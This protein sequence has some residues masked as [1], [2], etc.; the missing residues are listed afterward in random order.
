VTSFFGYGQY[1]YVKVDDTYT[2]DQLI[3][4][5]LVNSACDLVSNVRYQ[6]GSG[7]PAAQNIMAAGYF[8]RNG[9]VFPFE[10]GIVLSTDKSSLVPGPKGPITPSAN[11]FRWTGDVDLNNLINDAGGWPGGNDARSTIIDFEFISVQSTV[12]FEY[13]FASNSYY[14]CTWNCD[15]G[16]LFGAWLIDTTT[17]TGQNLAVIPG[18]TDPISINTLRD[19]AKTGVT[20]G[21]VS[22]NAHLFDNAYGAGATM[23]P[24][25]SAPVNY[26]GI[27]VAMQSLTANVVVGRKYRIKLAIIDFCTTPTHTSA[28]FF[29]E[30]S[31]DIGNLD[32]GAPVLIADDNGLCVGDNYTL[33]SGLDPTLFTF[34]WYKDGIKIPGE[35]SPDL[36]VNQT[37]DYAVKAYIPTVT[38]C[39]MEAEP[40][41]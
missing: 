39:V 23:Q 2:P 13:V 40:V 19:G 27:T 30:G 12:G 29:N 4:E 1:N 33:K 25:I 35:T 31:F 28:V 18:T 8:E 5:V 17:N 11:Q 24:A 3:K 9:S 6:Y 20:C 15:N 22:P 36:V 26:S 41:R 21:G 7:V 34:E 16:A 38:S 37:G 10:S 32:L 14:G